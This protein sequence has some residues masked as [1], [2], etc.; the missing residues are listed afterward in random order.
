MGEGIAPEGFGAAINAGLS[1]GKNAEQ[2]GSAED[3][4]EVEHW[5]D[6]NIGF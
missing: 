6:G 5:S 4:D 3:K 2:R 1:P